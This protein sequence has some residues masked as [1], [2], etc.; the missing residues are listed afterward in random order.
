M[1]ASFFSAFVDVLLLKHYNT[2]LVM[3]STGLLGAASGLVGSFLLL[4]KR[5]LIGDALS[6]A[7]LPGIGLMFMFMVLAGGTG[8]ALGGLLLG[9]AVTGVLGVGMVLAIRNTTP[10]KDDTAMGI[11]LSVF[12]GIGIAILGM[13]QTMPQA[14]AAGLETFIYGKTASMVRQDL[15]LIAISAALSLIAVIVFYK[16]FTLLCFDEQYASSQGWPVLLLELL[17]MALVCV[18]TVVG[19]QAVGLILIIA[20]LI[21][22]AAAA[23]FWTHRMGTTLWLAGII[24]GISGWL[25]AGVSALFPRLPAGAVIVLMAATVFL[26]SLIF[27]SARGVLRRVSLAAR[28]RKKVGRQHLLRAAF[29]LMEADAEAL[30][31][32]VR[33]TPVPLERLERHRSWHPAEVRKLLNTARREDHL[34]PAESGLVRLSEAGYGEAQRITRNHRLWEM[35]LI[36]HADVAPGHVDRDADMVE[37]ILGADLVRKLEDELARRVSAREVVPPSPHGALCEGDAV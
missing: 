34:E 14:S 3:L 33:N 26:F 22:P 23:R 25:G 11:V 13:V 27:G 12:F 16:E 18:V 7:A 15:I 5:S 36:E 6:H 37:H 10:L 19:L 8:K 30:G 4:R 31:V 1:E 24:G 17:L 21:T 29:E 9:A 20:L 2:R 32:P 28:L 35:Y